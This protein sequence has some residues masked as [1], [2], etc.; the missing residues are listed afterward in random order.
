MGP[1]EIEIVENYDYEYIMI[2]IGNGDRP[3]RDLIIKQL[4][5]IAPVVIVNEENT[6]TPHKIHDNALSAARISLI[7]DRYDISRTTNNPVITIAGKSTVTFYYGH[8]PNY[9]WIYYIAAVA[10][11]FAVFLVVASSKRNTV[12]VPKWKRSKSSKKAQKVQKA[13]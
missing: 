12:K 8:K 13:K 10:V 2:K 11:A 1:L 3:N 4:R 9:D 7:D 5:N 6:S